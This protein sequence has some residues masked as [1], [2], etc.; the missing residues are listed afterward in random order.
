MS[1]RTEIFTSQFLW[2]ESPYGVDIAV[3]VATIV[4]IATDIATM[5]VPQNDQMYQL[6]M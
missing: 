5:N 1:D 2:Y 6:I 4:D 3:D